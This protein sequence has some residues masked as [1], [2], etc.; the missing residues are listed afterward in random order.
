[1]AP[2]TMEA[3]TI[4]VDPA[5]TF[6]PPAG[7]VFS[8]QRDITAML[9]SAGVTAFQH[10]QPVW[11]ALPTLIRHLVTINLAAGVHRPTPLGADRTFA[12]ELDAKVVVP[13]IKSTGSGLGA[14]IKLVGALPSQYTPIVGS[15]G[16]PLTISSYQSGSSDE[17]P[18]LI[19]TGTPFAGLD[20][21]GRYVVLNTGLTTLIHDHTDD[22]LYVTANI[23]PAPTSCWVGKPSTIL[24][25]STN[26]VNPFVS[27]GAVFWT[28][29]STSGA[30]CR[31]EFTD[32]AIQPFGFSGN[33]VGITDTGAYFTRCVID[34]RGPYDDF[35]I[36]PNGVGFAVANGAAGAR[37]V[38][39]QCCA[40]NPTTHDADGSIAA[41]DA[42]ISR[43]FAFECYFRGDDSST[44]GPGA[45]FSLRGTV[46]DRC[47]TESTTLGVIDLCGANATFGVISTAATK[48]NEIRNPT[49]GVCGIRMVGSRTP[50][51]RSIAGLDDPANVSHTSVMFVG[52]TGPCVQLV[53]RSTIQFY[54]ASTYGFK[55]GGGNTDVGFD[56]KGPFARLDLNTPTDVTGTNGDVRLADGTIM[57]Y[58]QITAGSPVIDSVNNVV[59]RP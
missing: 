1:M 36:I 3:L 13:T 55:D 21:K 20:L 50:A 42:N 44:F 31:F 25:N 47:G 12:W 27:G 48:R 43:I 15:S 22:T 59:R 19:F 10:L 33:T 37:A 56:V 38:F 17:N 4:P 51:Y 40:D 18:R 52:V 29:S 6:D 9:A 41:L 45:A 5:S 53:E 7:T 46:F 11:D 16:S 8:R 35:G 23:S 24:R 30:Y 34:H 49:A 57:T 2:Q 54:S 32:L 26:D 39:T 58:A 28:T 14:N